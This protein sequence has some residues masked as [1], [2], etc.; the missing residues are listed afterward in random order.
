MGKIFAT[1]DIGSNTVHLLIA[2]KNSDSL[3]RV[4][5]ESDWQ[6]LG[7][8]VTQ[9]GFIPP[10][11]QDRLISTLKSYSAAAALARAEKFYV[12]ATE[13]MRIADNHSAVLKRIKKEVGVR[14]E[15]ISGRREAELGL[16]GALLDTDPKW[17]FLLV[18]VGGGS[19]QVARCENGLITHEVSLPLGTGRLISDIG[20]ESPPTSGQVQHLVEFVDRNLEAVNEFGSARSIVACGGVARG[21]IRALHP[22][23][24]KNLHR[25]EVEFLAWSASRSSVQQLSARFNVKSKRAATLLPG[26]GVYG[27]IL[28]KFDMVEMTVSEFGVREGA[29][30][31]MAEGRL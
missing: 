24:E 5:N 1:A 13:A 19:A 31:E 25:I 12:F 29:I 20:L 30:L 28:R 26:S 21:L 17:P 6:S 27:A 2:E 4:R 9:Y 22:D 18:E 3:Q 23:G 7:Q 15:L 10:D 16:E 14:V 8:I 11:A